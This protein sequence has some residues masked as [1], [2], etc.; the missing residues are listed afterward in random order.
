MAAPSFAAWNA[1]PALVDRL[2]S[3]YGGIH[4]WSFVTTAAGQSISVLCTVVHRAG[5]TD[6]DQQEQIRQAGIEFNEIWRRI[7]IEPR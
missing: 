3:G 6:T 2:R 7:T 5:L 1:A 4:V